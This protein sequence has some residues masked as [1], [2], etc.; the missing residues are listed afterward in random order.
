MRSVFPLESKAKKRGGEACVGPLCFYLVEHCTRAAEEKREMQESD[1]GDG[2]AHCAL[3]IKTCKG[4][5]S[6][7]AG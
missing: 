5:E 3:K 6:I 4:V 7:E 1:S 2:S